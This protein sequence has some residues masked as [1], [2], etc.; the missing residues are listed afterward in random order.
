MKTLIKY[1]L[2][3]I[4]FVAGSCGE[5]IVGL[6]DDELVTISEESLNYNV[7]GGHVTIANYSG[8]ETVVL[9]GTTIDVVAVPESGYEFIGW[10]VDNSDIPV[11][12]NKTYSFAVNK[13][14]TLVAKFGKLC[15]V[16]V[17][18]GGNGSVVIKDFA[19]TSMNTIIG[20]ELTVVATPNANFE[21]LGWFIGDSET[22]VST[23]LTYTFT[24]EEEV[25]LVAKFEIR[26]TYI[27]GYE[28]VDLG[29]P[30]GIKWAAYNVGATKPEEYGGY[31]AW[32]ETEEKSNYSWS[33][34]KWCNGSYNTMTKYCTSSSYGTVDN[35]TVLDLED[36]VAHVKWGGG[37]RM[38]TTSEQ[39]ELLNKCTWQWTTLNGVN[40][41][42]VTGPNGN[43]IFVPAAG[44]RHGTSLDSEEADGY[45]WSATPYEG[46]SNYA[47][48]LNFGSSRYDWGSSNRSLG[49]SVRP[50]C[51]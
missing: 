27:D 10:F 17:G 9:V 1:L 46:N 25:S 7:T 13:N 12:V 41:Y 19:Y 45:Y 5:R 15:F 38:P 51:K 39:R 14:V 23:E 50:V 20:T 42:R 28:Y 36:D 16:S 4:L 32:G 43:S 22:P 31:Y 33:T 29:L 34:Y 35:K 8:K 26:K 3:A 24:V 40:G 30:S 37:W 6:G 44:Y 11:S 21:F 18:S 47:C 48:S 2:L 49:R